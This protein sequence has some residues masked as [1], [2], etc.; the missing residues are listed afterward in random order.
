MHGK[1]T[2]TSVTSNTT[3]RSIFIEGKTQFSESIEV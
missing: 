1:L 3:F 2:D